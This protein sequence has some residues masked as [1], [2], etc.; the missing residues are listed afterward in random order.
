MMDSTEDALE[1]LFTAVFNINVYYLAQVKELHLLHLHP[2]VNLE[3]IAINFQN[4]EQLFIGGTLDHLTSFIRH[5]KRLK[6]VI[7]DGYTGNHNSLDL[8][9]LDRARQASEMKFKVQI[10]VFEDRSLYLPTKWNAKNSN[11]DLV[12]ITRAESIRKHFECFHFNKEMYL[13][14]FP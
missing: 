6:Y 13:I 5:S 7:F 8:L 10:G 14:K 9:K 11:L 2:G 1:A 12:E 4:L 3:A